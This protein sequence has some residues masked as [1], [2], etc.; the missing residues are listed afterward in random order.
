MLKIPEQIKNQHVPKL[1]PEK[2]TKLNRNGKPYFLE[3]MV[4]ELSKD[5]DLGENFSAMISRLDRIKNIDAHRNGTIT[6]KKYFKL[7]EFW[8]ISRPPENSGFR[9]ILISSFRHFEYKFR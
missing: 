1:C 5:N 2:P 7:Q 8:C 3:T 9:E 4:M 6:T